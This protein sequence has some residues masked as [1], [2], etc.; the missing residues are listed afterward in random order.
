MLGVKDDKYQAV[1]TRH[2]GRLKPQ[3]DQLFVKS[4]N[5]EYGTFNADY[6]SDL[7]L[8]LYT[9]ELVVPTETAETPAETADDLWS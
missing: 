1:Y 9:P 4:L 5:D 2:F 6:N 8:G 7:K 3:R